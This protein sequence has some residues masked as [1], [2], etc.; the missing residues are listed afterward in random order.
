MYVIGGDDGRN[1]YGTVFAWTPPLL[2]LDLSG[3][4]AATPTVAVVA[5][6]TLT[7]T[8]MTTSTA[9]AT[10]TVA[11]TPTPL[12]L[13]VHLAVKKQKVNRGQTQTLTVT[14]TAGA[15]VTITV[16]FPAHKKLHHGGSADDTGRFTWR[17]KEPKDMPSGLVVKITTTATYHGDVANAS[18]R[19]K[20]G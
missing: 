10:S 9:T 16:T 2:T 19:F 8:A 18:G 6:P 12:P 5:N 4:D 13:T 7:P 11:P 1:V 20:T 3:L 14:T 17:F 15:R